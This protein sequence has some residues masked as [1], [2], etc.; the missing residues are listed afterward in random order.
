M[1]QIVINRDEL[2]SNFQPHGIPP[3][4][5]SAQSAAYQFGSGSNRSGLQEGNKSFDM[6][7]MSSI[8]SDD[9]ASNNQMLEADLNFSPPQ[10]SEVSVYEEVEMLI[11]DQLATLE[12]QGRRLSDYQSQNV[13]AFLQA[14]E[15][16]KSG[17]ETV[18]ASDS[19]VVLGKNPFEFTIKALTKLIMPIAK[20]EKP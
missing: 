3:L 4:V 10:E 1:S 9:G 15:K 6:A 5:E 18:N 13:K 19:D 7:F 20:E 14:L 8:K 16:I 2:V 17:K 12:K 11:R